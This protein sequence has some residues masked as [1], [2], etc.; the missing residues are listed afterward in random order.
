MAN[1]TIKKKSFVRSGYSAASPT[2]T[3]ATNSAASSVLVIASTM[4]SNGINGR[5][6]VANIDLGWD[7][8]VLKVNDVIGQS[9][10]TAS[11]DSNRNVTISFSDANIR[12]FIVPFG[13][14]LSWGG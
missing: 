14:G 4:N 2:I 8:G 3:I 11:V 7:S 10:I 9:N 1:S 13:N 12:Y 6:F 5:F